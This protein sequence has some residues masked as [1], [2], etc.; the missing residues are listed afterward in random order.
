MC[1]EG[2]KQS[3]RTSGSLVRVIALFSC[4]LPV[5][6][7]PRP[8]QE[9]SVFKIITKIIV[10]F[11]AKVLLFV[12]VT[13][14]NIPALNTTPSIGQL[15]IVC[16][17]SLGDSHEK[18]SLNF[19]LFLSVYLAR[20]IKARN[21]LFEISSVQYTFIQLCITVFFRLGQKVLLKSLP[22]RRP[23]GLCLLFPWASAANHGCTATCWL[24][25]PP[26]FDVP[27]L[28]TRCLRAY[29]RVPRSSGGSWNLWAGNRTGN[30]A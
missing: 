16:L 29:P 27:T 14:R 15:I 28:A 5:H 20:Y 6:P 1:A 18:S 8:L 12:P 19:D 11:R 25:V 9:Q 21:V 2:F 24:I 22:S 30:F 3:F 23:L 13:F 17:P 26:A 4:T 10:M 7:Q